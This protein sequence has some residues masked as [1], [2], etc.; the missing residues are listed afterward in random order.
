MGIGHGIGKND[1]LM[2]DAFIGGHWP[3]ACVGKAG[4]GNGCLEAALMALELR[5]PIL[6]LFVLLL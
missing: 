5:P 4:N 3:Q 6:I 1:G 2:H